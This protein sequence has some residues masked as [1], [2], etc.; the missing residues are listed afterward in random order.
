[1]YTFT[2]TL[3]LKLHCISKKCML[4][5]L[6]YI[7]PLQISPGRTGNTGYLNIVVISAFEGYSKSQDIRN[8]FPQL[9]ETAALYLRWSAVHYKQLFWL[10]L[11]LYYLTAHPPLPEQLPQ[12]SRLIFHH[13]RQKHQRVC[14]L[15]YTPI[16]WWTLPTKQFP[17]VRFHI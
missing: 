13:P 17:Q 7:S 16:K 15:K 2:Y 9:D 14:G 10:R 12:T 4:S 8:Y 1:M 11:M 3:N 5:T 6:A